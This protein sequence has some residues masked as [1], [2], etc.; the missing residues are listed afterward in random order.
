MVFE[1]KDS[2][3]ARLITLQSWHSG[4]PVLSMVADRADG[5]NPTAP[6]KRLVNISVC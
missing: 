3:E 5:L 1:G 2:F 6:V 4:V